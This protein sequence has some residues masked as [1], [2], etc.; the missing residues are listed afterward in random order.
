MQPAPTVSANGQP[1][2]YYSLPNKSIK[3]NLKKINRTNKC[4]LQP[5]RALLVDI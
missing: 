2:E 1:R 3:Y 5:V 4:A